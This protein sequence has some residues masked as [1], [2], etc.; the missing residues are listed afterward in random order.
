MDLPESRTAARGLGRTVS[1]YPQTKAQFAQA[2][3]TAQ[4]HDT[5]A[6]P[7]VFQPR[8]GRQTI[9]SLQGAP[10]GSRGPQQ[11]EPCGPPRLFRGL[12]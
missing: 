5:R 6:P 4:R 9:C 3:Y 8:R 2:N 10:F 7:I 1:I 12:A 11:P